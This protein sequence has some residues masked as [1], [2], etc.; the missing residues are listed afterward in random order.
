MRKPY[1]LLDCTSPASQ[2]ISGLHQ[3]VND[4]AK[5]V[6]QA[7]GRKHLSAFFSHAQRGTAALI[8]GTEFLYETCAN[9]L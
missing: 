5:Q 8:A 3:E 9:S 2:A 4:L 6:Q 1:L 7:S